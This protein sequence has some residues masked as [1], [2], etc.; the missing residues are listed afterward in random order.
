MDHMDWVSRRVSGAI[1]DVRIGLCTK[2]VK[3]RTYRL[4]R[5]FGQVTGQPTLL[6][7][8]HYRFQAK[9]RLLYVWQCQFWTMLDKQ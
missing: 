9:E 1:R 8:A 4:V 6:D 3:S 2:E 7:I 5:R